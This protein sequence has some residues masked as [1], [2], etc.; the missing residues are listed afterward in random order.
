MYIA[1]VAEDG[2]HDNPHLDAVRALAESEGAEVV[3]VCAAIESEIA[4]LDENERAEF[5][6]TS[7]WKSRA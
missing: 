7:A 3:P 1:N 6:P 5:S 4:E 2:F